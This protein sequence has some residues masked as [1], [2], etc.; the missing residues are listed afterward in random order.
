MPMRSTRLFRLKPKSGLRKPQ[1]TAASRLSPRKE[2]VLVPVRLT[3]RAG[4]R[5]QPRISS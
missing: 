4:S 1:V 3:A 2:R 5:N